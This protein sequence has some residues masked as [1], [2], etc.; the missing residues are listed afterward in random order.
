MK[1]TLEHPAATPDT[2]RR[3]FVRLAGAGAAALSALPATTAW[4]APAAA[5][6]LRVGFVSPR[7]GPLA[8][9]GR[10]DP[11]VIDLVRQRTGGRLRVGDTNYEL[12]ILDRDSQS[13]PTRATQLAKQLI[14][15]EAI[16]LMLATSTP[17]VV[18][19]VADACEAAGMP[20]LSTVDPWESWYFGRGAKPGQPSPFKWTYHFSFGV[21]QFAD[22][23]LSS[24]KLLPTNRKVGVLYP[25]DA[26]GNAMREHI[27]PTLRK[28]GFTVIDPGAYQDGTTDF[29]AQIARFKSA[30]VQI[31]TG[32]PLPNDFITFLRQAAQQ[33]LAR[34]LRIVQP[35]KFG[36][37]PSDVEA[38]GEL[39]VRVASNADWSPAFP[40]VSPVAG[41]GGRELADAYEKGTGRQWTQQVGA[42][43]ALF[44]AGVA[45]LKN[46]RTPKDKTALAAAIKVLDVVTTVG[47][48]NFP[49][50]PV[51]N[52]AVTPVVG[53][54][55]IKARPG[56]RYKLDF[57]TVEHADDPRV[58]IQARLLPYGRQQA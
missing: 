14:N 17:E 39:G 33:G 27:V 57:V 34:R 45:A 56:S 13:D 25:N 36:G 52:V 54:Q 1:N 8:E 55:W 40:Y 7:T 11:F 23:Y 30:G 12:E 29:S 38:L 42:T 53:T 10:S 26:D 24:W 9:F 47:R 43:L 4:A 41:I 28:G 46:S 31:L 50:G 48:V 2:K 32:V 18:N 49:G 20:C 5:T 22:M 16:D 21:Q 35:A 37:F 3:D 15:D 51:P 58:R 6:R 19:P 44:D